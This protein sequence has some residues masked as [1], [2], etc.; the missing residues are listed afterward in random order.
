[1]ICRGSEAHFKTK[2]PQNRSSK[3]VFYKANE[4]MGILEYMILEKMTKYQD[5]MHIIIDTDRQSDCKERIVNILHRRYGLNL[6][7][8]ILSNQVEDITPIKRIIGATIQ[9]SMYMNS[10]QKNLSLPKLGC[11]SK[12]LGSGIST[13][14]ISL[15]ITL[16]R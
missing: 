11:E 2:K 8:M 4:Y 10:K 15:S 5:S 14:N 13:P 6:R 1:M 16:I 12:H 9:S 7:K 3:K